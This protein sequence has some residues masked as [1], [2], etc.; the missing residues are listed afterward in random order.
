V[1][2]GRSCNRLL[3]ALPIIAAA[4][5]M[6]AVSMPIALAQVPVPRAPLGV[7]L[8]SPL[9]G[10][11]PQRQ[12]QVGPGLPTPAPLPPVSPSQPG[13]SF[14]I[15]TVAIDGMTAYPGGA[16]D[17]ALGGLVGP[18]V[19]TA[20]IET[21]R[22]DIVERYRDDGYVYTTVRAV[23]RGNSLRFSVVEGYVADV[24]LDGDAG[25]VGTQVLRFLEHLV[26]E[27]PLQTKS[28]ERWLLLA[29]DIPGLT[30]RSTLDPSTD[31][32]GALTLV[33]RVTRKAIS[34]FVQADNRAPAF[35]GPFEGLAVMSLN[36][37][38]E[39][40][41]SS[42]F[43]FY[44]APG[45]NIFGQATEEFFVGN[46][47][48]KLRVYAGAGPVYPTGALSDIGY[49][50]FTKEYGGLFTYP[51]LR[52]RQQTLNLTLGFDA[53]EINTQTNLGG[54]GEAR[55]SYDSLRIFRLGTDYA[56]FDALLGDAR[57]ANNQFSIL[58][59]QGITGLG[60]GHDDDVSTPPPRLG[61]K[62]DFEKASGQ[63]SRTQTLFEPYESASVA[64]REA[65]AWQG[66]GD[67][68]PPVEKFY[69]G[70]PHFNRG[71]YYGQIAGDSALSVSSELQLNTPVPLP[72]KVPVA[73]NAQFYTFWDWGDAW[74]NTK[75]ESNVVVNSLGGGVRFFIGDATEIDF[76]GVYRGNTY[77]NGSGPNVS[78][79]RTAAFYWQASFRF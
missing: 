58:V 60:A 72:A 30:V 1:P 4:A 3:V 52:A 21:A 29:S 18:K 55:A 59:S 6:L 51:V 14:T 25:P 11:V 24:K 43:A 68:L 50:T 77:P 40:G 37:F 73:L 74:Q 38:T 46:S 53:I 28:L 32:P 47:G 39:F 34:G 44:G 19:T 8:G 64:L 10:V 48:L 78:A 79:L 33:A 66:T 76:E 42:Q 61:E 67:V 17:A 20:Q 62:V 35:A 9:P 75:D 2:F 26:G 36:S 49:Q 23:I 13:Q 12:P 56:L 5:V 57:G 45:P 15:T 54:N 63:F 41:E 69:L 16:F 70:G 65:V 7:P 27:K 31:Q 22:R 71:Y